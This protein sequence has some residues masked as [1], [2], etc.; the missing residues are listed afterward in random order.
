MI[1]IYVYRIVLK[2]K[3]VQHVYDINN[4]IYINFNNTQTYRRF[5]TKTEY[6]YEFHYIIICLI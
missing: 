2:S 1:V 5:L 6:H 4:S 3:F